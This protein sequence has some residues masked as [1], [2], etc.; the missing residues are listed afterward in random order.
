MGR[1][2]MDRVSMDMVSMES[3]GFLDTA[4]VT[5]TSTLVLSSQT[6]YSWIDHSTQ[7]F[8]VFFGG[9]P[10]WWHLGI[11]L[12][13]HGKAGLDCNKVWVYKSKQMLLLPCRSPFLSSYKSLYFCHN[14][15]FSINVKQPKKKVTEFQ[16][17]WEKYVSVLF[18]KMI[19]VGVSQICKS[20][21]M[22]YLNLWTLSMKTGCVIPIPTFITYHNL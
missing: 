18:K 7:V 21:H 22:V 14:I 8:K 6:F 3:V 10:G 15:Y 4:E 12:W 16:G 5:Q 17:K 11:S 13:V 9:C 1:V 20:A 19:T 2:S